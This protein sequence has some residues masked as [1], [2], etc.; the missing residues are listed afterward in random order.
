MKYV[1]FILNMYNGYMTGHRRYYSGQAVLIIVLVMTVAL[2]VGLSLITRTTVDVRVTGQFEDSARAFSAAE[3]GIEQSLSGYALG[4]TGS[5]GADGILVRTTS[6]A[7]GVGNTSY[8][9]PVNTTK[10]GEVATVFLASHDANGVLDWGNYYPSNTLYVCWKSADGSTY[11]ALEFIQYYKS[12]ST[13][14]T[15]RVAYD[16]SPSSRSNGFATAG[17]VTGNYCGQ[18]N[19]YRIQ[20]TGLQT[21]VPGMLRIRT[22]YDDAIVYVRESSD[23]ELVSQG[24]RIT[25]T[26]EIPGGV[27]RMITVV[28]QYKTPSLLFDHVLYSSGSITK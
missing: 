27:T 12:G 17:I 16:P 1:D 15:S 19:V 2:T 6:E 26:G 14:R 7:E 24:N 25:S 4:S 23:P 13:Y 21:G 20:L 10:V 3:A 22:Y 8:Q 5:Q 11:P 9:L 28:R 18:T